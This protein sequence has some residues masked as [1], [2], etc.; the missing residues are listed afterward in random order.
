MN[1]DGPSVDR[2][3][4]NLRASGSAAALCRRFVNTLPVDGASISV[5][6]IGWQQTTIAASDRVAAALE[7]LQFDLGEGPH[8]Q[9]IQTGRSVSVTDL[10]SA[11]S[12]AWPMFASAALGIGVH[13][14]IALPL[15]LGA[16][17]IGVVDLN[18]R[19]A[20]PF[21]SE[22]LETAETLTRRTALAS[23]RFAAETARE[24]VVEESD[25]AP[26]LR[27][28]VHQAIGMIVVQLNTTATEA[29]A[30]LRAHAFASGRTVQAVALDVVN[31]QLDFAALQDDAT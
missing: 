17:T 5:F 20:G 14:V 27:R 8:W 30:R 7:E 11:Q 6:G 12:D 28:E 19:L 2:E 31:R 25:T 26:A 23:A 9:A 22:A 16:T 29:F 13:A 24:D 15:K 4:H 1:P 21:G 18:R 10:D 3:A